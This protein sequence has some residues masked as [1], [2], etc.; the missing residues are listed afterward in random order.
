MGRGL[1]AR[2]LPSPAPRCC[3]A[4]CAG[5]PQPKRGTPRQGTWHPPK[6]NSG[7]A[8][9]RSALQ[10]HA[11]AG[12]TALR[13]REC[14]L[15]N[16]EGPRYIMRGQRLGS[17]E[18]AACW[19]PAQPKSALPAQSRRGNPQILHLPLLEV[20]ELCAL[21]P[22]TTGTCGGSPSSPSTLKPLPHGRPA[23]PARGHRARPD[24]ARGWLRSRRGAAPR[25]AGRPAEVRQG[26]R[27][28]CSASQSRL[29]IPRL[30]FAKNPGHF[31]QGRFVKTLPLLTF[32]NNNNRKD[33]KMPAGR[34]PVALPWLSVCQLSSGL[35]QP[36]GQPKTSPAS[37]APWSLGW[38]TRDRGDV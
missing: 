9:G 1:P 24:A 20:P 14:L 37:K 4:D 29:L 34:V 26:Q 32:R 30:A 13:L 35:R 3:R 33:N 17:C 5:D 2:A 7:Q 21:L 16:W 12:T 10:S 28:G 38:V 25:R 27:R 15:T 8:A 18:R 19:H 11:G 22:G 23:G 31:E 6:D 36:L